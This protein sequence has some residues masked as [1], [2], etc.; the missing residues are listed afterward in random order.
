MGKFRVS[1]RP[2][3]RTVAGRILCGVSIAALSGCTP[4]QQSLD[5]CHGG[6]AACGRFAPKDAA[7]IYLQT[8]EF[9][10]SLQKSS[11]TLVSLRPKSGAGFDFAPSGRF[12]ERLG[13]GAYRLGDIDLR[14][15]MVGTAEWRDY[16]SAHRRV[17]VT[18]LAAEKDILAAADITATL[19]AEFPLRVERRWSV[20]DGKL[21]LS[22]T[23]TNPGTSPIEVGG[24][25]LPMVF[26]N[27]LEGRSLDEA[28]TKASFADAYVGEDGG[29]MQVT[30][31][32]GA[33]PALLVLPEKN[34]PFELYKPILDDKDGAGKPKLYSDPLERGTTFEGFYDWMV[35]AKGFADTEWKGVEQ[36]NRPSSLILAPGESRSFGVRFVLSPGVR[37]I[38]PTLIENRR[39]VA[40]GLP[41]YVVPTDISAQL[42]VHAPQ[43]VK[44]IEVFP[45]GALTVG[46][47]DPAGRGWIK[48]AVNGKTPGRARLAITYDDGSV[49]TVH[50]LVTKPQREVVAAFGHFLTT[51]QWYDD[52]NDAFGR[53][54]S[55]MSY[56]RETGKIVTQDGRVWIAGL[57]DEGGAGSWLAA[58]MKQ[59]DNPDPAEVAKFETFASTVL[60]GRLQI[61]DGPDKYGVRNSL[62]YYDKT[63]PAGTYDPNTDWTTWAAWSKE[64]AYGIGRSFNYPHVASAWWVLYR[65]A[66]FHDGLTRET[67]QTYL[68]RAF[69][70][71]VAMVEKAPRYVEFGQMEGD[72]FIDLIA[73]LR[74]EGRVDDAARLE[75]L[76]KKRADHWKS[77]AYP[78]GSE[79]PWDSTGQE[80]VYAWLSHFGYAAEAEK[81]RNVIL[82]YDPAIPHWGYNGSARRYWD[83]LFG[84]KK[85]RIER[86]LHHYGSS[87][88]A[89]PLFDSYRRDPSDFHL[90]RVAYG[91]LMGSLTNIDGEGFGSAAFH[92]F[93]DTMAFDAY[94]GDYGTS[95]FGHAY[96]AASYLVQHPLFGWTGFGGN[97]SVMGDNVVMTPKDSARSR[98]FVAP[99]G[100]W[101]T[102]R[103]GKFAQVRYH[104]ATGAIDLV[105]EPGDRHTPKAIFE[106]AVTTKDG[107]RY[108]VAAPVSAERGLFS[109]ALSDKMTAVHL[110]PLKL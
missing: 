80:E 68:D 55:I 73:D 92:S 57:S 9:E 14:L 41:G 53:S 59:L 17:A 66:R 104:R 54:P 29:Y 36:W 103:A 48:Y 88:N 71:A 74:R 75:A 34:T 3:W 52:P 64:R 23:L 96:A 63:A 5:T 32:N 19:G 15:R 77:L 81:T 94:S 67:W 102:A 13:N 24:L 10:F 90:L 26:D 35:A 72:V 33:G 85:E 43:A 89:I 28:H 95:F 16:S 69:H 87:I 56:D 60:W 22:F 62:F 93:P 44:K 42:F 1:G 38:E 11:Q 39:P 70:T 97:V 21:V 6:P 18:P 108:E 84:G 25:G 31:L 4:A 61:S 8:T 12:A 51:K 82:A 83:F 109:A 20:A 79:M 91:G 46:A 107:A 65:L 98:V 30:R 50:Y 78:F 105:F 86:Q 100:I 101:I 40:I 106:I 2:K 110:S 27:I 45:S 49:Q 7:Q 58:I 47:G 37:D 76:M 99:A